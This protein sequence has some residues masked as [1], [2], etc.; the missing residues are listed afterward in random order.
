MSVSHAGLGI[1]DAVFV[2]VCNILFVYL[3]AFF[4]C[5]CRGNKFNM[6]YVFVCFLGQCNKFS[7][8]KFLPLVT[9]PL[10]FNTFVSFSS[11]CGAATDNTGENSGGQRKNHLCMFWLLKRPFI[12]KSLYFSSYL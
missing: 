10:I 3:F 8:I 11:C 7:D 6:P 12:P 2:F 4:T 9:T 5:R 1:Q